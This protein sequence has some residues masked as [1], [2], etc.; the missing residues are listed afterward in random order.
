MRIRVKSGLPKSRPP[1]APQMDGPRYLHEIVRKLAWSPTFPHM[2]TSDPTVILG[3]LLMIYD[4][5][6]SLERIH[7]DFSMENSTNLGKS[8][9]TSPKQG[10]STTKVV[11]V[12]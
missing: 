1:L 8:I 6:V 2:E 3:Y 10:S 4:P 7:A 5:P 11:C 9:F 12:V